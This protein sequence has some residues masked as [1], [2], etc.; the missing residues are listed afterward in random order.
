MQAAVQ[1]VQN[2]QAA[3][4]QGLRGQQSGCDEGASAFGFQRVW[5]IVDS[6]VPP[7]MA[8]L[9]RGELAAGPSSRIPGMASCKVLVTAL[10]S[11]DRSSVR[12][13]PVHR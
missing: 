2:H 4:Q 13:S 8:E 9:K 11:A 12:A 3:R 1:L 5:K 7:C 6:A 10:S